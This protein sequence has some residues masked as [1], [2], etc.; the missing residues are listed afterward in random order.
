MASL[1]DKYLLQQTAHEGEEPRFMMLETIR[2]IGLEALSERKELQATRAVHA[3]YFL[4]LA[5]QAEPELAGLQQIVWLE[6]LEREH[7]NLRAALGWGLSP[8]PGEENEQRWEL[9][10]RLG[11]LRDFWITHGYL[12]EGQVFLERA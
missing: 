10:L 9:A 3:A 11:A 12:S 5:E 7:D 2:E 4:A 1:I 6:R 8:G